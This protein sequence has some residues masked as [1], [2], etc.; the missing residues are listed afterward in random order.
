[1]LESSEKKDDNTFADLLRRLRQNTDYRAAEN[2]IAFRAA[3]SQEIIFARIRR[4]WTQS[5]LAARAGVSMKTVSDIEACLV[6]ARL[7]T[8]N[9][10]FGAL[11]STGG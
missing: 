2:R 4:N 7:D 8:V 10:I 5:E 1:M 9:K 11:F 6:N 3:I